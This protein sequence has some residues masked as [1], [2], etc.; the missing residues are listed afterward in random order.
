MMIMIK[1]KGKEPLNPRSAQAAQVWITQLLPCKITIPYNHHNH[2]AL[3]MGD[4]VPCY[5][6]LEIVGLL[7]LL[8]LLL[9]IEAVNYVTFNSHNLPGCVV[10]LC[11]NEYLRS[12]LL[13][14]HGDVAT[15]LSDQSTTHFWGKVKRAS[16]HY[17]L[18]LIR[19][20][21]I[22]VFH[23]IIC[24]CVVAVARVTIRSLPTQQFNKYYS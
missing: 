16:R 12:R 18:V 15:P 20:Y 23:T 10:T 5:G 19:R 8:L 6:A 1:G 7:W 13:L 24:I 21:M 11:S 4:G 9:S 2:R 22:L 14:D 3:V 17:F